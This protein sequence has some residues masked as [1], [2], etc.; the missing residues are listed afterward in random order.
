MARVIL[1]AVWLALMTGC[2]SV[3]RLAIPPADLIDDDLS[4]VGAEPEPDH[5]VWDRFLKTYLVVDS[6][7][8][9]RVAYADVTPGDKSDLE[10]YIASLS[11]MDATQ[12]SRDAQLAYWSNLYNATT[13]LVILDHYPVDSIRSIKDGVFDLGPWEE[14]RLLV[15]GRSL[16]LHD[17]EHGIV[18]P[19]WSDTPEVH[20]LLNCAAV[21]CP[22]LV[23][24]AYTADN[25][26]TA[27]DTNARSFINSSRGV[28]VTDGGRLELSKI[29]LW[30]LNDYG[31]SLGT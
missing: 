22:T 20:Y 30:Y 17:I 2:A 1:T 5:Q 28:N 11:D 8:V 24:Y 13:V 14:K 3:E 19:L 23:D 25:I 15:D 31:G 26:R 16:S 27:Q 18:R 7:G 9:G 6:Q 10:S 4:K 12:W 21:G 29:Y